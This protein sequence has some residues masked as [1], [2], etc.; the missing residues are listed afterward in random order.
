[1]EELKTADGRIVA[2]IFE[3]LRDRRGLKWM[4]AKLEG[5]KE[6]IDTQTQDEI[7]TTWRR[8]VRA[9]FKELEAE[10]AKLKRE[11]YDKERAALRLAEG[12][13]CG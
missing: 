4:F 7:R 13:S 6:R 3:D 2:A 5:G 12:D 1:M 11:R 9:E 10:N 8:I